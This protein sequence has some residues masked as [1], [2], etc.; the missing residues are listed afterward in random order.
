MQSEETVSQSVGS[1]KIIAIGAHKKIQQRK[2]MERL[3]YDVPEDRRDGYQQSDVMRIM[4]AF[5][6]MD[7]QQAQEFYVKVSD[8]IST[9]S[10]RL[11]RECMK[12]LLCWNSSL[13]PQIEEM[14]A[15]ILMGGENRRLAHMEGGAY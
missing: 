14:A 4:L 13:T 11:L 15:V 5:D 6:H 10:K 12:E 7:Q 9:R 8:I 1:S 3:L 2:F